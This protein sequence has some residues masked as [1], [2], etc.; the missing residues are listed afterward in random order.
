MV[1][2]NIPEEMGEET[3]LDY[4][5]D[6]TICSKVLM[7]DGAKKAAAAVV[8]SVNNNSTTP[9]MEDDRNDGEKNTSSGTANEDRDT[10]AEI[11]LTVDVQGK[12]ATKEGEEAAVEEE[13]DFDKNPTVLY[14]YVQKKLWKEAVDR[15]RENPEETNIWVCRREKDGRLRW[16]LLPLHA[17][18]VFKAPEEVVSALLE[19]YPK[20][21]EAKDDQGMLPLHLAFRN[22]AA[23]AVVNL[24]LLAYPASVDVPDRKGRKPMVLAQA[25]SS[26]NREI[27]IEALEKG[28]GHYAL[29]AVGSAKAK[30]VKE[31]E[32]IYDQKLQA[33]CAEHEAK[34]EAAHA[35]AKKD[36]ADVEE[37][38][39]ELEAELAKT[40]ETSQVLVDHVNSLEAQL[41]SRSDTERFLATKIANLDTK[42]QEVT[43]EK[44]DLEANATN[45]RTLLSVEKDGLSTEMKELQTKLAE[46]EEKLQNATSKYETEHAEWTATEEELRQK[47]HQKE[48]EW[49]NAQASTAI[50]E[51]QLKK[52][53]ENESLLA[54]QVSTLATRLS[55]SANDSKDNTKKFTQIIHEM[56]K[57][58]VGL[59][60]Q[61]EDMSGRLK[62]VAKV[63]EQMS[64]QQFQIVDDAIG[65]EEMIAKALEAHAKIVTIAAE[66]ETELQRAKEEREIMKKMLDEQETAI[67][68]AAEK[69]TDIMKSIALQGSYMSG[70]KQS[71]E[72]MLSN[73]STMGEAMNS[74]LET[75]MGGLKL[76]ESNEEPAAD[77]KKEEAATTEEVPAAVNPDR[78]EAARE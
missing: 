72:D 68:M 20:G 4:N 48:V 23:E 40:Q 76:L 52:R 73:V 60:V 41:N 46:T 70:T 14:A 49:A 56:E 11:P 29:A 37:K 21:A 38:V 67:T 47:I 42:L 30:I 5:D 45:E 75:V 66:Q 19:A 17:A 27:F 16:R 3:V 10:A 57:E 62:T 28:P 9:H 12:T 53:M 64:T 55:E 7:S 33:I 31:Q 65:H 6:A 2:E 24:L 61:I 32:E 1:V 58:R 35:D 54:S 34:I 74:A 77:A 44:E 59:K 43:K 26:P 22:G 13:R 78:I 36:R 18:I 50:V 69:R 25:A 39:V 63:I 71:R 8:L 51:A 15:A